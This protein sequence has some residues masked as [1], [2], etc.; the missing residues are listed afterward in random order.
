[1]TGVRGAISAAV[2]FG[3]LSFAPFGKLVSRSGK[4][5]QPPPGMKRDPPREGILASN[6]PAL[7]KTSNVPGP[8]S[9]HYRST[10][11]PH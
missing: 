1:M 8:K 6:A 2:V 7:P 10:G 5:T 3:R 9:D 11:Q 4:S